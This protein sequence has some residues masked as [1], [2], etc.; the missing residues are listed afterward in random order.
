[1]QPI[2]QKIEANINHSF[3]V[4]QVKFQYFPNPLQFHPEIEILYVI[5]G[6]GTRFVGDSVDRFGPGELVMIGQNVP[7][8]WYSDEK[9]INGNSNL[10][11]EVI[12]ILFK[13][14]IFGEQFWQLPESKSILK[15]FQLSQ[16]GIKLT[17][18]TRIEVSSLMRSI[19]SSVGFNRI[20]NLLSMLEIIATKKNY[21]VL[22][23]PIVQNTIN[24]SDSERLNKVYKYVINNSQQEITL[25][26]VASIASLSTP[27]FCRYFKKRTNK[28]FVQLLNE[29]RISHACRLLMEEDF[30]V[31]RICF[32]CGYTNVSYFIKQFKRTTG[33]TP[34]SYKKKYAD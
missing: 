10:F 28:T 16:R 20:T 24:E 14:E 27:S 33:L 7:H 4:E 15:L 21:H 2:F 30:P 26:K 22:A 9:Y 3:Y 32:I 6:S 13:K 1:M 5:H 18:K 11:S 8:L 19:S 23:S 12:F 29:I 17:G 34:L 25:E 31:E